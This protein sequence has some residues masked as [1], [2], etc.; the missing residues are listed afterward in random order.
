MFEEVNVVQFVK[1]VPY[2]LNWKFL[3]VCT[4]GG[5]PRVLTLNQK[6]PIKTLPSC[7][8]Q[9]MNQ[10]KRQIWRLASR[11][12]GRP[13]LRLAIPSYV[14]HSC[15][16]TRKSYNSNRD[17]PYANGFPVLAYGLASMMPRTSA[18]NS[19]LVGYMSGFEPNLRSL[20]CGVGES[21][22][23]KASVNWGGWVMRGMPRLLIIPWLI[24]LFFFFLFL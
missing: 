4:K 6:N 18:A 10:R 20:S 8:S 16:M 5:Q 2:F 15:V 22:W 9:T 17:S 13:L 19:T 12:S 3:T 21:L 23:L 14:K 7:I 11:Q 24:K 1:K